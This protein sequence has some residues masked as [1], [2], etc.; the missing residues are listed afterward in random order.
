MSQQPRNEPEPHASAEPAPSVPRDTTPTWEMELLLSGALVF[1]LMQLPAYLGGSL[2]AWLPRLDEHWGGVALVAH[3]YLLA[4]VFV[5]I[6]TFV[7]HLGVRGFWVAL[8]G[9]DSIYPDGV[10]WDKLRYGPNY[11]R[12]AQ[13]RLAAPRATI[14]RADNF[15]TLVFAVGVL[16]VFTVLL[17]MAAMIPLFALT[18]LAVE[19][20]GGRLDWDVVFWALFVAMLAPLLLASGVDRTIGRRLASESRPARALRRVF[21]LYGRM[22]LARPSASMMLTFTSHVGSR[23]GMLLVIGGLWIALFLAGAM[24]VARQGVLRLDGYEYLPDGSGEG[25]V[26]AAHYADRRG[27]QYRHRPV[28][29][30][31][32]EVVRGPYLRLFVPYQPSRHGAALRARC[33]EVGASALRDA[34]AER[35]RRVQLLACFAALFDVRLDGTAIEA[36]RL[37]FSDDPESGLRGVLAFIPAKGLSAG[38][39]E[40]D[41]ARIPRSGRPPDPNAPTRYRI[42]FWR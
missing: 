30:V 25:L 24:L 8:I 18:Y 39:H 23:R 38:R 7:L 14:D 13:Q 16:M 6:V 17:S 36:L 22:P 26:S 1:S 42:P 9:L 33:P 21:D 19:L 35:E 4:T 3:V 15:A 10:R 5:L 11:V 31:Q 29:Y 20:S 34:G 27:A 2:D 37:D 12:A 41:L 28:P 32:S 40:L